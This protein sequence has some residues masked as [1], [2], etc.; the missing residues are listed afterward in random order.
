MS[1]KVI[2]ISHLPIPYRGIGSWTTLYD[3]YITKSEHQIDT[4]ICPPLVKKKYPDINY[5]F[6]TVSKFVKLRNKLFSNRFYHIIKTLEAYISKNKQHSFIIQI[7]DNLGF[8]FALNDFLIK[9]GQRSKVYIQYSFHGFSI[10]NESVMKKINNSCDELILLTNLAYKDNLKRHTLLPKHVSVLNNGIDTQIFKTS[11]EKQN[12]EV[13]TFLWCS[14]DR[15]KK[16]LH[17]ILE[18]WSE[19]H[20]QFP[21]TE[22]KIVGNHK[23]YHGKGIKSLGRIPN[24]DLP[25]IYQE[26][27][28]YLFPTLCH[29]GFGLTLAEALHCGCFCIASKIGGVPEVLNH[30]EYGWLINEPHNEKEWLGAMVKYMNKQPKHPKIPKDK[31]SLESW[32]EGMNEIITKAKNRN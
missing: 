31:F 2:L 12:R 19:F 4:I 26:A 9:S 11:N 21:N 25:K 27:D 16:G 13:T 1:S 28:V 6:F 23:A 3:N 10:Q 15:P 32:S 5:E 8:V 20:K 22:L 14:Q 24:K 18:I 30:G 17:I 29:E 7:I